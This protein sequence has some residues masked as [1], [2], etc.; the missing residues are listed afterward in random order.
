MLYGE[1]SRDQME[2]Y[3]TH[4]F[5]TAGVLKN[6][7]T[8]RQFYANLLDKFNMKTTVAEE[9]INFKRDIKEFSSF[10]IFCVLYFL[11]QGSLKKFFTQSEI[12]NLAKEKFEDNK[13]EFPIVFN[14][15][16]QVTP[17]QWIG[18]I[19]LQELMQMKRSRMLNYDEN[20]QRAMERVKSGSIEVFKPF[21]N[22]KSV[23]EIKE[24]ML[25]G[26]YVPDP[27]TLNMQ[28]GASYEYKNHTLTVYE[29]PNGMFNLNDGYHRYLA[30]SQI[31][32]FDK[33]FDYVMELRIICFSNI[34][35]NNFIFQQD[36][37]TRMRKIISDSYNSSSMANA[38]IAR[39]KEDTTCNVSNLIG[40]NKANINEAVLGK[41]ISHFYIERGTKKEDQIKEVIKI[42]N[43]LKEKFNALTEQDDRFF[44]N[45]SDQLLFITIY[46]FKNC[47][48]RGRYAEIIE[49]INSNVKETSYYNIM[50]SGSIRRKA[51]NELDKL[52]K[53]VI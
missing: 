44:G 29:L 48:E 34:K 30:M 22:R 40:R 42:K 23:R 49:T 53:E 17:D 20:E 26:A 10:E 16:V 27:I 51:I 41:L 3:A 31:N 5:L 28:D 33:N 7:R 11:D 46:V 35:A 6:K 45:Y 43:E 4:L 36:Q 39:L 2:K 15:M 13:A 18:R 47:E 24:L 32:D 21:V 1:M 9:M 37:K 25:N 52:I 8:R 19:T 14:D 38:V 12:D 50:S